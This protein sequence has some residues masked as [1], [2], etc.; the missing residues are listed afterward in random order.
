MHVVLA[1]PRRSPFTGE[2]ITAPHQGLLSLAAVLR[3]GTFDD[4]RSVTVDVFDDQLHSLVHD[5]SAPGEF[6]DNIQPDIFGVQAVTSGISNA[7]ALVAKAKTRNPCLLA[8]LGGVGP[9]QEAKTLVEGGQVDV[10][11]RGEG[12]TSFSALVASYARSGR[13][14]LENVPGISFINDDGKFVS[15]PPAPAIARLDELPLPARDLVDMATY[16]RI[17]HGRA[18]NLVTSRGCSFACSYCYSRHHWGR[19][20]RRFSVGRVIQ[21][22]ELLVDRYGMNRIRIEDDDFLEDEIW[23]D[24]FCTELLARG[25]DRRMEWESKARPDHM[26]PERLKLLRRA[27]CFRFLMGVE[28][29]D[30]DRLRKLSRPIPVETTERA[31]RMLRDADIAVQATL[32]LGIPGET[33]HAMRHTLSWLEDRLSGPRDIVSPCFFVPFSEAIRQS[34]A[35]RFDFT[36]E[37]QNRDCFTGHIPVVSSPACS[38]EQ[39]QGLYD[40][41]TPTRRGMYRH[42]AHLA[43]H[44]EVLS[45]LTTLG[46]D[47]IAP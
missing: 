12:E 2:A 18:G 5:P 41:L 35:R 11:V 28:T 14:L 40:D 44:A 24:A 42:T 27:G 10:V 25:L 36:I 34:V 43:P 8:V 29:L 20:Q 6:L 23:V 9:T 38:L 26:E 37:I 32:I 46:S 15:T 30:N 19:G 21:E 16:S 17:S 45:R 22:I 3:E 31:L 33:E 13:K 39:L 1:S 47:A 4:T 7:L